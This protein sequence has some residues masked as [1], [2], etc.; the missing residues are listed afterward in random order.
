MG[1]LQGEVKTEKK[2]FHFNLSVSGPEDEL[3]CKITNL[4]NIDG[5]LH[6]TLGHV[7]TTILCFP[8]IL[9]QMYE[10]FF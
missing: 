1:Y 3:E 10:V 8:F 6:M 5:G 4:I 2:L 7:I 9:F